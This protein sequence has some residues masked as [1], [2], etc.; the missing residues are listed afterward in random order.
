MSKTKPEAAKP[1]GAAP[2]THD[3]GLS[4]A[5]K[6][7]RLKE[8]AKKMV[9]AKHRKAFIA[10]GMESLERTE[11]VRQVEKRSGDIMD[12]VRKLLAAKG[13]LAYHLVIKVPIT[14]KEEGKGLM[15]WASSRDCKKAD[16]LELLGTLTRSAHSLSSKL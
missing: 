13:V 10:Q 4:K 12:E 6:V 15:G 8:M 1:L 5:E 16:A 2:H 3:H 14:K 7:K 9:P 11:I